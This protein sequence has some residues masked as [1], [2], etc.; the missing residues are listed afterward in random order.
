MQ[1]ESKI[2]RDNEQKRH[3]LFKTSKWQQQQEI[4]HL[5]TYTTDEEK[6]FYKYK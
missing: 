3:L 6:M 2:T 4:I 5:K 1:S